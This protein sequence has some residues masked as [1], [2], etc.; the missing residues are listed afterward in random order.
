LGALAILVTFALGFKQGYDT[1]AASN[2]TAEAAFAR[3]DAFIEDALRSHRISE[4]QAA[5]ARQRLETAATPQPRPAGALPRLIGMLLGLAIVDLLLFAMAIRLL[6]RGSAPWVVSGL[7]LCFVLS[8]AA[9]FVQLPALRA[10]GAPYAI[11]LL[12][13]LVLGWWCYTVVRDD[14]RDGGG[15]ARP[16]G[17]SWDDEPASESSRRPSFLRDASEVAAAAPAALAPVV[18]LQVPAS[19]ASLLHVQGAL[20]ATGFGGWLESTGAIQ[21]QLSP[22]PPAGAEVMVADAAGTWHA[23]GH[24]DPTTG[25]VGAPLGVGSWYLLVRSVAPAGSTTLYVTALAPPP[26]ALAPAA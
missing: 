10:G 3:E 7:L 18:A 4:Q 14:V 23:V 17:S 15:T 26:A 13:R 24:V 19:P 11:G 12:I 21:V 2:A 6:V 9:V 5:A 20:D 16:R 1:A 22:P 25:L 8:V